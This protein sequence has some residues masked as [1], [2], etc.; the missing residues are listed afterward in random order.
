MKNRNRMCSYVASVFCMA[1][2]GN[3]GNRVYIGC[4]NCFVMS[5]FLFFFCRQVN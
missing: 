4:F 3:H 1:L 2:Y 5:L